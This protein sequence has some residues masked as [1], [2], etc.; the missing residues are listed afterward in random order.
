MNARLFA[1]RGLTLLQAQYWAGALAA[2]FAFLACAVSGELGPGLVLVFVAAFVGGHL[3]GPRV[4][5][6]GE[7]GWTVFIVG[8]FF[9]LVAQV[10]TTGLDVVLAAC[11]FAVLLCIHRLWHR[12]TQRDELLLMLMSLLLLCAGAALSAE[13]TFGFAFLAYSVCATWAMALTHLR[14]EIEAGR[15]PAGSAALL[16]SRRIATPALLGGLAALALMG[17]VGGAIVFFTFPRVTIGGLRR[18]TRNQP[19]PGLG[20]RVD[21]AAHG[22]VPDDPRVV[23][24]VRLAPD[25]GRQTLDMHWRARALEVWTGR[26]WRMYG[27]GVG[28]PMRRLP[29]APWLFHAYGRRGPPLVADIEAVAGFSD[30]VV[31]TPEGW[32]LG[33]EFK[34]PLNAAGTQP[35]LLVGGAGDLFY[36]PVDVGD[37]HYVVTVND[38]EPSRDLMRRRPTKYPTWLQVDLEVPGN[39]DPRVAALARQLGGGKDP[40][41]A[42][43]AIEAYLS[44]KLGYTRELPGEVKDPIADFLFVRK[45]GHC[46][47]FS[48]AM[49]LMLRTLGIPA[50]N[51]T[52]YYGGEL[53][54]GGYYAVRAGDAHSWVEVYFPQIGFTR[55]DPTPA[56]ERG[57]QLDSMWAR[58]VLLWDSLQQ[59]WRA[60]VV[61]YDLVS[62]AQAVKR[63]GAALDEAARRLSGKAGAAPRLRVALLAV[64]ALAGAGLL[65]F[66]LRRVRLPSLGGKE[67]RRALGPDQRRALQL[68]RKARVRLLRAGLDLSPATTPREAA[69]RSRLEAASAVAS[70]YAAARWGGA[71]LPSETARALLRRLDTELRGDA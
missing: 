59:K 2:V 57:S 1:G 18:A 21:L 53:T 11:Q 34:R 48:S 71:P 33:V 10:I 3:Y 37:L 4:Y 67:G 15:G 30:G 36:Q 5:G 44:S 23:L 43:M 58:V 19:A 16:Q 40:A 35:H 45:K 60:F 55:F 50:R 54:A 38:E 12:R 42:A 14:F 47:L 63:I 56:G 49:V 9:V 28:A 6:K 17:L 32:P 52:G 70:A 62:Q 39:L 25:P 46:E 7:W 26:G 29:P 41:D 65:G 8:A 69:R 64:L 31:I 66:A 61:D 68:W 51:V 13:L 22:V 24:R 27:S 20:D